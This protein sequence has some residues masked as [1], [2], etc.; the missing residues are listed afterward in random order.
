M[1]RDG[2]DGAHSHHFCYSKDVFAPMAPW[3]KVLQTPQSH[4][5]PVCFHCCPLSNTIMGKIN[6]EAS[7]HHHFYLITNI[8]KKNHHYHHHH[9]LK[10]LHQQPSSASMFFGAQSYVNRNPFLFFPVLFTLCET[11]LEIN[12]IV[13]CEQDIFIEEKGCLSLHTS[14]SHYIN[15]LHFTGLLARAVSLSK[16]VHCGGLSIRAPKWRK[17]SSRL[18]S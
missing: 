18:T 11:T 10:K 17:D 13:Y 14:P 1:K 12:M 16:H 4:F 7:R 8:R 6:H 3:N 2:L 15:H 5:K 9:H